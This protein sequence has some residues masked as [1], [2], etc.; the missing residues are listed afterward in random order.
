MTLQEI[1]RDLEEYIR[2]Q[3]KIRGLAVPCDVLKARVVPEMP[4]PR[5]KAGCLVCWSEED[6][7]VEAIILVAVETLDENKEYIKR[8]LL[9][10]LAH[11]ET[12]WL[13]GPHDEDNP[14][15]ESICKSIGGIL[16]EE[17]HLYK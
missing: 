6:E 8:I 14:I 5:T 11:A 9:H 7:F 3:I 10:E 2:L 13:N 12:N 1:E 4:N 15:F 17:A 16:R